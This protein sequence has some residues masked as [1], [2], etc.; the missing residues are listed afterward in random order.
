MAEFNSTFLKFG[1]PE[2]Q[3]A[4]YEHWSVLVRPKQAT[5]GALVLVS[6]GPYTALSQLPEAA[7]KEQAQVTQD[8]AAVLSK[9]F[10]Y[11]KINYLLL[12]MVDPHVHFHVLPRYSSPQTFDTWTFEDGG[13]P[14]QPD[15]AGG[16][17]D[18]AIV[19]ALVERLKA[20]WPS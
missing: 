12:M 14:G 6:N 20:E 18:P 10:S 13:W 19:A 9:L 15:L 16:S 4:H 8:I 2:N 1:G 11:D 5:L 3:V 17:A 7:F